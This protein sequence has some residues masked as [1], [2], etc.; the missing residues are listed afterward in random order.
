[1]GRKGRDVAIIP[2]SVTVLVTWDQR[3]ECNILQNSLYSIEHE[4]VDTVF[5]AVVPDSFMRRDTT[6]NGETDRP[7]T[8]A[9][10]PLET[11]RPLSVPGDRWSF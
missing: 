7:L 5:F 1:M 8:G 11:E 4:I 6:S 3:K 10:W 2:A 9:E